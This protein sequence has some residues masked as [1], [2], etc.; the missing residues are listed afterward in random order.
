MLLDAHPLAAIFF[1]DH[2]S[3]FRYQQLWKGSDL[4]LAHLCKGKGRSVSATEDLLMGDPIRGGDE[5]EPV[6]MVV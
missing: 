2:R 4:L 5:K 3:L 1:V 6:V